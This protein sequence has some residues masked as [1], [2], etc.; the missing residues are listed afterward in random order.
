MSSKALALALAASCVVRLSSAR[1]DDAASPDQISPSD[2]AAAGRDPLDVMAE[3]GASLRVVAAFRLG[4]EY[5]GQD[6]EEAFSPGAEG[7][8]R[9]F[10]GP[11]A[12]VQ[13]LHERLTI[14]GGPSVG[15]SRLSPDFVARVGASLGF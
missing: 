8:A 2:D 1:A 14:V 7:G 15:L 4:V 9:H 12:S 6:L 3:L 11:I 10:L 5:V 13:L